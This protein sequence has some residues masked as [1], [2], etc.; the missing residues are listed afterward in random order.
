MGSIWPHIKSYQ[1][2]RVLLKAKRG[3]GIAKL[4]KKRF[5]Y[6]KQSI[7]LGALLCTSFI[8]VLTE[9]FTLSF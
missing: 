3:V 9:R 6:L 1:K 4:E 2:V 5:F 7:L 8:I